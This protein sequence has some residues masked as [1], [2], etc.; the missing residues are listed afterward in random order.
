MSGHDTLMIKLNI[1]KEGEI[2]GS[3]KIG[4]RNIKDTLNCLFRWLSLVTVPDAEQSWE[5]FSL[6]CLIINC[7]KSALPIPVLHALVLSP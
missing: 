7:L 6:L 5:C 2:A 4:E 1:E 3:C